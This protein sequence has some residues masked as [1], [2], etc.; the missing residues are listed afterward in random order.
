MLNLDLCSNLVLKEYDHP[1]KLLQNENGIL[2]S[3]V[4]TTGKASSALLRDAAEL[5]ICHLT[6]VHRKL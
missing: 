3:L 2:S 4:K 6:Y 1:W 5:V